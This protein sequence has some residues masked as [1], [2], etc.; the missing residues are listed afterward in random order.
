MASFISVIIEELWIFLFVAFLSVN[1]CPRENECRY[2]GKCYEFGS[3]ITKSDGRY[4]CAE[5]PAFMRLGSPKHRFHK[6]D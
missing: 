1:S 3:V 4:R 6:I 5:D 2:D